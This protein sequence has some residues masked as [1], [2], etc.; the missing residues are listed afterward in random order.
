M[1]NP[2][3]SELADGS[4][5]TNDELP[6][7]TKLASG[8]YTIVEHLK[9]GGFGI[10]YLATDTFG[11]RVVIKECF[12]SGIC[13]RASRAVRARSRIYVSN[14]S[15]L[16][17]K[18]VV[19]AHTLAKMSHPN[20]VKV[21]Q[22]FKENETAYMALDYVEG[23]DLLEVMGHSSLGLTPAGVRSTLLKLLD[24]VGAVH[25]KGLL[26]RDIS[27]DNILIDSKRNPIL[28]DFGAARDQ[29]RS[30]EAA[31][32][33][34]HVVKDGYSP[35]ELYLSGG[36]DQGPWSDL[37]SLAASFYH[38][39]TGEAPANSQARL[40]AMA[41]NSADPCVPLV[42]RF[43]AYDAAFLAAIDKAMS[44]L[45]KE[46]MQTAYQWLGAITG[47]NGG[48]VVQMPVAEPSRIVTPMTRVTRLEAEAARKKIG[49][50]AIFGGVAALSLVA[51]GV[52]LAMP[53]SSTA[54]VTG[55]TG[56]TVAAAAPAVGK[57]SA[58]TTAAPTATVVAAAAPVAAPVEPAPA[59]PVVE[60]KPAA[61]PAAP[62]TTARADVS[63]LTTNW[64]IELPFAAAD[65][66][67]NT[68][69][70]TSLAVPEWLVPGLQIVAVNGTPV[71]S[72]AEIS[73]VLRQSENPGDA[74]TIAAT[75][76]TVGD[77]GPADRS[78][79]LPV[80][81]RI[82]LVSGAEFQVRW[83]DGV[84]RTEVSALPEGYSGE[85]RVGDVIIGHVKSGTRMDGP[86]A[87]RGALETDI[88]AGHKSTTLAV[89]QGGQMWVVT[90]PLPG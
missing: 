5:L 43:D 68:V 15:S 41:S 46:R 11:R 89:Q 19:E 77:A 90:F 83:A 63:A 62:E 61:A 40:A 60:A 1:N 67:P 85:M 78:L 3:R 86:A 22:V 34:L 48:K 26:H 71:S 55:S 82:V 45:P 59:A 28:I 73:A 58:A 12:P 16:V 13:T 70:T 27:P 56:D 47:A 33:T 50:I 57:A 36:G 30:T 74:A 29:D 32:S 69:A 37:Y 79:E 51:V 52:Y 38:V 31:A 6:P 66:Q 88:I 76:S 7:G 87:L 44:V 72:L 75:L 53:G 25:E 23:H 24:A 39:I 80:V 49:P 42:G 20:I 14:V 84:W 4:E 81:H 18:F 10:T 8:A 9:T 54:K 64:T 2:E 65:G 35:Q 21:H 17:E